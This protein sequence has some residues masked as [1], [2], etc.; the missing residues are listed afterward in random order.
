MIQEVDNSAPQSTALY[1]PVDSFQIDR[2]NGQRNMNAINGRRL[3]A[4]VNVING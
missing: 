4:A 2:E 1:L 3:A